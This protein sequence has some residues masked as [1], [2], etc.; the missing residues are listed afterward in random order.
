MARGNL[1][2]N[3]DSPD[4]V[5]RVLRNAAQEYYESASEL[6]GAWQDPEAGKPWEQIARI[7][8]SAARAIDKKI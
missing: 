3:V 1:D 5:S 6:E 4:K 7:L 2:L 8:E